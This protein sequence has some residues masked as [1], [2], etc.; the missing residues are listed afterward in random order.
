M[1]LCVGVLGVFGW[2]VLGGVVLLLCVLVWMG[3][4]GSGCG[5][6]CYRCGVGLVL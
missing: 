4:C 2:M 3:L 5:G 1:Y 6:V